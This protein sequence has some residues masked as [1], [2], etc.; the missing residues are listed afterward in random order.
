MLKWSTFCRNFFH[1]PLKVKSVLVKNRESSRDFYV[2]LLTTEKFNPH[3]HWKYGRHLNRKSRFLIPLFISEKS[4]RME[5]LLLKYSRSFYPLTFPPIKKKS[6][7][8]FLKRL[9]TYQK[10][11]FAKKIHEGFRFKIIVLGKLFSYY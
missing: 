8:Q 9:H 2:P 7:W 5:S 4:I 11:A 1:Y 3:Y 6:F 10:R